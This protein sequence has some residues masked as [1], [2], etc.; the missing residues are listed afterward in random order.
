[1]DKEK[2]KKSGENS[3]KMFNAGGCNCGVDLST[4]TCACGKGVAAANSDL[5]P[6]ETSGNSG[7]NETSGQC[8]CGTGV[9]CGVTDTITD[10]I[11][12]KKLPGTPSEKI[13]Q[14][15]E[16]FLVDEK[17]YS[18]DDI[19]VG[20]GFE[21]TLETG[22]RVYYIVDLL[23][24]NGGKRIMAIKC[25]DS[26]LV[27]GERLILAYAR[28]LDSYQVPFA[29]VV[30]DMGAE[31]LETISG[32][33]IGSGIEAIPSKEEL[34]KMDLKFMGLPEKKI[35]KEK[36]ILFTFES[37]NETMCSAFKGKPSD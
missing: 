37:I 25:L 24:S 11:T 14:Q 20:E 10:F 27:V 4:S 19:T 18:K 30:N 1:M 23:V 31:V 12:G 21:I 36:R 35:E 15:T 29:A 16:H 34:E 5:V 2:G 28:L 22:E 32:K 8:D 33:S 26:A 9:T 3:L 7:T 13:R 17:G 6:I